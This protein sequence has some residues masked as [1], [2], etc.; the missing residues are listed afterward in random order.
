MSDKG[1]L[2]H[3]GVRRT[4]MHFNS[5]DSVTINTVQDVGPI[6]EENKKKFNS[7]GDKLSLGK[8]VNGTIPP[9]YL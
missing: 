6:V 9:L 1:V 7:Y 2:S 8:R 4:D 5:D 3:T